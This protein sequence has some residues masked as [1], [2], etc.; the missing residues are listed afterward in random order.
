[1]R[2]TDGKCFFDLLERDDLH[3]FSDSSVASILTERLL[4]RF[5]LLSERNTKMVI[6]AERIAGAEERR[7]RRDKAFPSAQSN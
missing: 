5:A 7:W 4:K 3:Y 2:L 6:H 1:M